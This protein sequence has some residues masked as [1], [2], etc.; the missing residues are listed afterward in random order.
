MN[1]N[2]SILRIKEYLNEI[3]L[4]IIGIINNTF[5]KFNQKFSND[6]IKILLDIKYIKANNYKS[7]DDEET[8]LIILLLKIY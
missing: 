1:N 5:L 7:N 4:I 2:D 3:F 8:S 6:D